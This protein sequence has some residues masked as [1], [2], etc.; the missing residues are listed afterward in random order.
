MR[1]SSNRSPDGS[2]P[3]GVFTLLA[4][5]ALLLVPGAADAQYETPP[6]PAG[7]ALMDV[8]VVQPDGARQEGMTLVVRRGIIESLE[9]GAPAPPGLREISWDE[10]TLHVYPGFVDGHGD[11]STSFPT[12]EREDVNSWNPTREVQNFTP[13]RRASDY[14]NE[15]GEGLS[16]ERRAGFV[17]SAVFPGRGP[18]PGQPSLILHRKDA[19]T[20]AE[21]VIEPSLGMAMAFQGAQGAYPGTL[22]AVHALIRQSFMDAEHHGVR[23]S[24][25]ASD[26]RGVVAPHRDEGLAYLQAVAAGEHRVFFRAD[27]AEYVRRVLA[28]ADELGFQPVIV[29]GEGAGEV[30]QELAARNVPVLLSTDLDDPD[31]WDPDSEEELTPAAARERDRLLPIYETAARFEEAGV[32]FALTSGGNGDTSPLAGAR[33]YVEHG[34]SAEAALRAL[35]HTPAEL[36]G[37]P[38]LARIQE[39]MAATFIVTDRELLEEQVGITWTF[40]NGQAE[41]GAEPLAEGE[42]RQVDEDVDIESVVGRWEGSLDAGGQDVPMTLELE[43]DDGSLVGTA[44]SQE[45]PDTQLQNVQ[46]DGATLTFVLPVAEMGGEARFEGTIDGDRM[47][48]SGSIASPQGEFPFT[49]QFRRVSGGQR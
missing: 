16:G 3:G 47:T 28:L 43:E 31:D 9:A 24:A 7:W 35:T 40:V 13:H 39:G 29:G 46:L 34:L 20:P 44:R 48:G 49:F 26:P 14:L 11:A 19:R 23:S 36:L 37:V 41:E 42:E 30:A 18:M 15:S 38:G 12:P 2:T 25:W 8:T 45:L 27:G 10:G 5:L 32:R 22:M 1:P 4:F 33:R 21:L 6:E 17:A